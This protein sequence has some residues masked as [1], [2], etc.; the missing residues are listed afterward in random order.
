MDDDAF[1]GAKAAANEV[2][3]DGADDGAWIEMDV[4]A[5]H[6]MT[7]KTDV[8]PNLKT[9]LS[10]GSGLLSEVVVA[11]AAV[12][13]TRSHS[14]DYHLVQCSDLHQALPVVREPS[15]EAVVVVDA[16]VVVVVVH[17]PVQFDH[18]SYNMGTSQLVDFYPGPIAPSFSSS[19]SVTFFTR[20][21]LMSWIGVRYPKPI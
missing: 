12:T 20:C 3:P 8:H 9:V 4:L 2:A 5:H 16:M 1:G 15:P 19:A 10:Q 7:E 6:P 13:G 11:A 14:E 18:Y 21:R 17:P